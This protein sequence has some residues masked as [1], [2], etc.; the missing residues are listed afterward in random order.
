MISLLEGQLASE[1]AAHASERDRLL[2]MIEEERATFEKRVANQVATAVHEAR[3]ERDRKWLEEVNSLR[4]RLREQEELF[5]RNDKRLEGIEGQRA[6]DEV[7]RLARL[8]SAEAELKIR[9]KMVTEREQAVVERDKE[10][11]QERA[12]LSA[13]LARTNEAMASMQ[14][15]GDGD[16]AK[17]KAFQESLESMQR[18]LMEERKKMIA[19]LLNDRRD[20]DAQRIQLQREREQLNDEAARQ[21]A[22]WERETADLAAE[23]A[24]AADEIITHTRRNAEEAER[25]AAMR[26]MITKRSQECEEVSAWCE[27]ERGRLI[28]EAK[29]LEAQRLAFRQETA[30]LT[31]AAMVVQRQSES[32]KRDRDIVAKERA[33]FEE[34]INLVRD[35]KVE[36]MRERKE[37]ERMAAELES[38]KKMF[39]VER[40]EMAKARREHAQERA[41]GARAAANMAT[42]TYPGNDG[43]DRDRDHDHDHDLGRPVSRNY[44]GNPPQAHHIADPPASPSKRGHERAAVVSAAAGVEFVR[45]AAERERLSRA[46]RLVSAPRQGGALPLVLAGTGSATT[47]LHFR[48][49]YAPP[50]SHLSSSF[51]PIIGEQRKFAISARAAAYSGFS[52]LL[53]STMGAGGGGGGGGG[54]GVSVS[55]LGQS[56]TSTAQGHGMG[57]TF[58]TTDNSMPTP[59][60]FENFSTDSD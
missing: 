56:T 32:V 41:K 20:L 8:E 6:K 28:E 13:M 42:L 57:V 34:Q 25:L 21:R 44:P 10:F 2:V 51:Q 27:K 24:R 43:D 38:K 23:K 12:R 31:E 45:I 47:D 7:E 36:V 52:T 14:A 18:D 15:V 58:A 3:E 55:G 39:E 49:H 50:S 30:H 5:R 40:L 19:E 35:G 46:L 54:G 60:H 59:S 48:Q 29:A 33:D 37:V 1:R 26:D 16:R 9:D 22:A 4:Q 53:D 17:L 11:H